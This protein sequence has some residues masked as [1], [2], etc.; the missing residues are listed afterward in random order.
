MKKSI[1][2]TMTVFMLILRLQA[3][4]FNLAAFWDSTTVLENPDK[5][6]YHHYY[7]NGI[8]HY[9]LNKDA[10]LDNIPGMDHLYLRLAWSF[11]EPKEGEFNWELI[12]KVIN[13][14]VAKGYTISFRI[15][16]RETGLEFATPEWLYKM[17][18]PGTFIDN[19]GLQTFEPDYGHPL[20]LEKLEQF[21]RV[22][23]ERYDG[24]PWLA[25]VD[26]GS[27]GDWGEGHTSFGTKVAWSN[28]VLKKH[29]DIHLKNYKRTPIVVSDDFLQHRSEADAADL[30]QYI[31][32]NGIAW[33]DD[34]I[35]V[36]WYVD[37]NA[38]TYSVSDPKIFR[39]SWPTRP[40]IVELQHYQMIIDDGNWKGQ[41]GSVRGAEILWGACEIMHPT[42]IGYHGY[43]DQWLKDNPNLT[44]QLAN[45]V[46]YWYF[47]KSIDIPE[48]V[49]P[50]L[51]T[52]LTLEMENHGY[53][54]AYKKY[55]MLVKLEGSS[56]SYEQYL[57]EIDNRT[58][59]PG[60]TAIVSA[61]LFIPSSLPMGD[62]KVKLK[63]VK[64]NLPVPRTV[65]L[66][67][68]DKFKDQNGF[69][70]VGSVTVKGSAANQSPEM[71]L[72]IQPS[73]GL[74][75]LEVGFD[76]SGSSDADG[77]ALTFFL[78]LL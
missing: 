49:R 47:L 64:D 35:L 7:D 32:E 36:G 76:A 26:I 44:R 74:A 4:P 77:D 12:D 11:L 57:T 58:W 63:M 48:L 78:G 34:S 33:R 56:E 17:G 75:P 22:F 21:H 68:Q 15:S 2:F 37:V 46:G 38:E 55:S 27:Y 42:W 23:A 8:D 39:D 19:W 9:L 45:K 30:R 51:Q 1:F 31:D 50:G 52:T 59:M 70:E 10:D 65:Y 28:E 61:A 16:C 5:G 14:W 62:Y 66:A 24:Q 67:L 73:E 60:E 3:E 13:K 6:W 53:A 72:N 54:P 18:L 69:Y 25:Y 41:D 20:F 71:K 43:A 40:T 29:I